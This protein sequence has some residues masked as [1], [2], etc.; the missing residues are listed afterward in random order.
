MNTKRL[1]LLIV[2]IMLFAAACGEDDK[3][4]AGFEC[5]KDNHHNQCVGIVKDYK[6]GKI[7]PVEAAR[8]IVNIYPDRA[9]QLGVTSPASAPS[10]DGT[11]ASGTAT[12]PAGIAAAP[13][14]QPGAVSVTNL[15]GGRSTEPRTVLGTIPGTDCPAY[16]DTGTLHGNTFK[17]SIPAG[18]TVFAFGV[19]FDDNLSSDPAR[20]WADGGIM[21]FFGPTQMDV[22]IYDGA[23]TAVP[24]ADSSKKFCEVV[25]MHLKNNWLLSHAGVPADWDPYCGHKK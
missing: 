10:T 25:D 11:T 2:G 7:T 12:A 14:G 24:T 6:S 8:Q 3:V 18:W 9:A 17:C 4:Q 1:I 19:H 22:T 23:Y 13:S 21:A 5:P 15:L 16:K 20:H